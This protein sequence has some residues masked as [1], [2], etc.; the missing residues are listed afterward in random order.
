MNLKGPKLWALGLPTLIA[1]SFIS[2]NLV[3]I[4]LLA[5]GEE[6]TEEQL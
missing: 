1:A 5:V 3:A 4:S 6:V 2:S